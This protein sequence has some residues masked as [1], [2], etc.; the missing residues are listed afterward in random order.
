MSQSIYINEYAK[1]QIFKLQDELL[2]IGNIECSNCILFSSKEYSPCG[3]C[4]VGKRIDEINN[5]I[6]YYKNLLNNDIE[7]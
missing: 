2:D 6:S 7:I 5:S 3:D 4:V 1:K